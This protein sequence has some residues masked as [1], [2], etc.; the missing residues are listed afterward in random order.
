MKAKKV[1]FT[2]LFLIYLTGLLLGLILLQ[3][4]PYISHK[5]DLVTFAERA[6]LEYSQDFTLEV[7][8]TFGLSYLVYDSKGN[9]T[10]QVSAGFSGS[11][12]DRTIERYMNY[13]E[14]NES[15]LFYT[16]IQWIDLKSKYH[17]P[18]L[19][20]VAAIR[21]D[22]QLSGAL[23]TIRDLPDIPGNLACFVFIW[24]FAFFLLLLCLRFSAKKEQETEELQRTYIATMNH[25]LKT[26][27]TSIKALTETLLDGYVTDPQK[28]LYYYST[29]LKEANQMEETVAEILELSKLQSAKN[30]YQ[31]EV[32]SADE[33]FSPILERYKELCEDID[34]QFTAPNFR[35]TLLPK[36]YTAPSLISRVL[37]LLLHNA[38]KFTESGSGI[39]EVNISEGKN[40]ITVAV[41]DNGCGISAEQLPHIF[42]R[43]YQAKS[44]T[45]SDGNTPC[46]RSTASA[47]G[48]SQEASR[49]GS[50]LGLSIV[51][52][53]LD[54][55]GETIQV[56]SQ[57]GKGSVFTFTVEKQPH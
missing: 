55:L 46:A 4:I 18:V 53:I 49:C 57:P 10:D 47:P 22:N 32:V 50:G 31:K 51:K 12:P 6:A 15:G 48:I 20:A 39:I 29:I 41:R 3:A 16:W 54:G 19:I 28:Q 33:L 36:L 17:I 52:E 24:S 7:D 26:P 1:H 25:D 56:K 8:S 44:S 2:L 30:I 9:C 5:Q 45:T 37:D 11:I 38:S 13:L 35:E 34:I 23:L 27:I 42:E 14:K 43:F 40:G 21:T